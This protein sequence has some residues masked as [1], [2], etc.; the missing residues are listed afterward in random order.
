MLSQTVMLPLAALIGAAV[1]D[2]A[3][4]TR[5]GMTAAWT[6]W[7]IVGG[8][9]VLVI[10]AL[11]AQV[12]AA[13]AEGEADDA[14][15]AVDRQT[16]LI[17]S[18]LVIA[19]VAL[20][21]VSWAPRGGTGFAAWAGVVAAAMGFALA[22]IKCVIGGRRTAPAPPSADTPASECAPATWSERSWPEI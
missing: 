14:F 7:A 12:R 2:G 5:P 20:F 4:I 11:D 19:G 1:V 13:S 8:L 21:L 18:A 6:A 3:L 15:A 10:A 22:I 16:C 17:A 9:A